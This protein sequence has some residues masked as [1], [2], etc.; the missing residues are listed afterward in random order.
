MGFPLRS[1]IARRKSS[2]MNLPQPVYIAIRIVIPLLILAA[3]GFGY[4]KLKEMRKPPARSKPEPGKPLVETEIARKHTGPLT[5]HVDGT[6]V[7]YREIVLSSEV[8][9]RV[10]S[11]GS[12]LDSNDVRAGHFVNEGDVLVAINTEYYDLEVERQKQL[13][14]QAEASIDETNAEIKNSEAQVGLLTLDHDRRE[15]DLVKVK[16]LRAQGAATEMDQDNAEQ[17]QRASLSA[18]TKEQNN[19]SLLKARLS[20]LESARDL[21]GTEQ[22]KAELDVARCTIKSPCDGVVVEDHVELDSFVQRGAMLLKVQDTTATEVRTSLRIDDV[23]WLWQHNSQVAGPD[24]E[25]GSRSEWEIPDV[26]VSILYEL[27]GATFRWE[28]RLSRHE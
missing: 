4:V 23:Y 27:N 19:L 20:R 13:H 14:A 15:A 3:G 26:P 12:A 21:A 25:T 8:A 22:R 1:V 18:L 6:V 5:I 24:S 10:V 7:P 2:F 11:K 17:N 9:G 28:G 16:N